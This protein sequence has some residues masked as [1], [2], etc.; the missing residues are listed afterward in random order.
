MTTL[1]TT[2]TEQAAGLLHDI[3]HTAFSHVTDELFGAPDLAQDQRHRS[4][5]LGSDVSKILY[6]HGLDPEEVADIEKH[7]LLEREPPRLCADRV[8][9]SLREFAPRLNGNRER[10]LRSLTV[11]DGRLVF[12]NR[13]MAEYF[14]FRYLNTHMH[15]VAS[16][17]KTVR[18]HLFAQALRAA[19]EESV[20]SVED[21]FHDDE[22]VLRKL[23]SSRSPRIAATLG[24]LSRKLKLEE[25]EDGQIKLPRR[26]RYVDPEFLEEGRPVRLSKVN[27]KYAEEVRRHRAILS[28]GVSVNILAP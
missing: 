4:F 6:M 17:E 10:L 28:R 1:T 22:H 12:D 3:S 21:L 15:K 19:L 16:V 8:D 2:T 24:L 11:F 27:K 7:G 23:T 14:A 5:L 26:V 25:D 18:Q 9:Y 13:E 20:I